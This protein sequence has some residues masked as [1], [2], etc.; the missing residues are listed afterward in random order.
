MSTTSALGGA[1]R[2]R[3][4]PALIQGLGRYVDDIKLPGETSA[5]FVRSPFARAKILSID[6]SDA[7]AMDGVLAVYTA[8][9]VESLGPLI[10]QLSFA[11]RPLLN[12]GE[13]KHVG[14][15]VAMVIASD[16]YVA[17]DAADAI[18]VDYEPLEAVIDLK[19]SLSDRV[20]IHEGSESNTI[21]SWV[22]PFGAEP[23]AQ[24]AVKDGID[25][26]R[27]RDDTVVVSQEMVN[28][29]LIPT[30]IEP[31]R[32][33]A[34]W[35]PGYNTLNVWSTTQIPH[36]LAGGIA[37]S[38]GLPTTSV[39]VVAPE[40][41]GG[42]GAKLN[43]YNDEI[44]VSWASKQLGRPV[45]WVETRR[46]AANSTIQGRGWIGTATIVGT[47]D[48]EILGYDF[49]GIADMGAYTQNFTVAIP[50][51]GLF[52][53]SG[54]YKMPTYWKIDCVATNTVTTDAY[55]GAGR[56]EAMYYIERIVDM[57]AREI[58]MDPAEVRHKNFIPSEEFPVAISPVG[59]AMDTGDY[60][61]NLDALLETAD[62]AG[63]RSEQEAARA[64][65]RLVGVGL[66]TYVEVCGFA[67]AGLADLGF[68]WGTYGLPTAFNG[69]GL[70]R[71]NPD[72]TATVII[73]TGPSGQGHQTTW[74][75]IV[76]DRL[77]IEV[78]NIT[79]KHGDTTDSPVGI[80]TFGSRSAAV[81][82]S[83]A[84]EA[85]DRVR[86]KAAK[87][88]AH[89]LEAS[90]EDIV[91]A[92]GGAHV[93]GSPDSSV[94]W[95]EIATIAYQT[96]KAPEGTEPGLE[97]E[98]FFTPANATWPFGSHLAMV[99]VDA[100]TGNV[101]ILRYIGMDDCGNVINPMIVDGQVHGG[102]TQGIGQALFE[103]A[104]YDSDGNLLSG[105]MID[106][107]IPTAGDVPLFEL[108]RTVTPT[109]V[110]PMGVKGI[111]EA[112]TIGSAQTI[113][114]A[115]VDAVAPLGVTHIDM[116]LRPR[117]VW[118]AIQEAR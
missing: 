59:F 34:E 75:Q 117:R 39:R 29:R 82:G 40:V 1:I 112:G 49:D 80:G 27:E 115:V 56:P 106:Y 23:E 63:L 107:P 78:D 42:F 11:P 69:S 93:A 43:V 50:F 79:V 15:A 87:L 111:G 44:L 25:A 67:P 94:A 91:F 100:E 58:G 13:V 70:V 66:S 110:N 6:T 45:R 76:S 114:N 35:N 21:I 86:V 3:E 9:D 92:D 72:A 33:L 89:L 20:L 46:E 88:A 54:Q 30:A 104:I 77:G 101:E 113:V 5:A 18:F 14:E 53:G 32:V 17:Q 64:A 71:V 118:E 98:V 24:Q 61:M 16:R 2:R 105:S 57:Y 28:Q 116:P 73:G 109:D 31:R 47:R 62:Y 102:I 68:N 95:G 4:D 99:E 36:A 97:S 22:G 7:L 60:A 38:L 84:Y 103:E 90:E 81:D 65:G 108:H 48:G 96:H 74:A 19:D 51:L 85:A 83:A 37:V 12:G 8:A 26:A 41:G 10:A 52:V 55:R